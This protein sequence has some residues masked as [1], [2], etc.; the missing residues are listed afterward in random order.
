LRWR[1]DFRNRCT[2]SGYQRASIFAPQPT[3]YLI[4]K[5]YA[6]H[7]ASFS[8]ESLRF[9][10]AQHRRVVFF[11]ERASNLFVPFSIDRRR[12]DSGTGTL[13]SLLNLSVFENVEIL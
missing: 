5:L 2:E 4:L 3:H 7:S 12:V 11:G 8:R 10:V 1:W 13:N 9:V 6:K